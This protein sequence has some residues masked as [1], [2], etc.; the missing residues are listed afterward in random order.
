MFLI[1]IIREEL[2]IE[3]IEEEDPEYYMNI[4]K[5]YISKSNG[6]NYNGDISL[7]SGYI[8]DLCR[9]DIHNY[10]IILT[11]GY[12][13]F[14]NGIIKK[15]ISIDQDITIKGIAKVYKEFI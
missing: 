5:E 9:N 12:A 11:G 8:S 10:K 7:L 6:N 1:L 4:L 14:F 15:K 13:N 2:Y 3:G